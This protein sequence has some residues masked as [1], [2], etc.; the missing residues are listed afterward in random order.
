MPGLSEARGALARRGAVT[1]VVLSLAAVG[2]ALA[3]P[4]AAETVLRALLVVL[5]AG[6]TAW[7][8]GRVGWPARS[9]PTSAPFRTP[10]E[11]SLRRQLPTG[12]RNIADDLSADVRAAT[13]NAI[14]YSV[15]GTLRD[16]LRRRLA[17]TY[18][19]DPTE[20]THV[21]RIQALISPP[22]WMLFQPPPRAAG[23]HRLSLDQPIHLRHLGT[24][25]DDLER[26]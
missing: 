1:A 2:I 3:W 8:L 11:E 15:R 18:G 16:E 17:D 24:I 9:D 20:P 21:G 12:L 4:A 6:G 5:A 19:L 25:L 13:G 23:G 26:L 22:A 7:L 14:P 10:D